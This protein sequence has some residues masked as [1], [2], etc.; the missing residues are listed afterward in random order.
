MYLEQTGRG[1]DVFLIHGWCTTRR[2]WQPLVEI[3]SRR[4]RLSCID[5]PGHGDSINT[6]F[7]LSRPR[8]LVD[9][10]IKL[11]PPGAA[12]VGWSLG[13]LLAQAAALQTPEH[14]ST[15][16]VL[17]MGARFI[18]APDWPHG[19]PRPLLQEMRAALNRDPADTLKDFIEF[20]VTD[21]EHGKQTLLK[22]EQLVSTPFELEEIVAGLDFLETMD[23]RAKLPTWPGR[24]LFA[25][26]EHDTICS[27]LMLKQSADL[28]PD[29]RYGLIPGAG[30]APLLSHPQQLA[31]LLDSF[32]RP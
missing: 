11:A 28:S 4:Y 26:G 29:S 32:L 14:I 8:D 6:G 5:L 25:A 31:D 19:T 10:L 23:L 22:L 30:H 17:C 15:C 9:E 18:A 12:W 21:S 20:Q 2:C 7:S 16:A 27:P 3:L 24:I 13:G 1:R